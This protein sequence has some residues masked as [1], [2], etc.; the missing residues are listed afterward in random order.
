MLDIG[1]KVM[2]IGCQTLEGQR[3]IGRVVTLHQILT[4]G[5]IIDPNSV[6]DTDVEYSSGLTGGVVFHEELG[7]Y[8]A[9]EFKPEYALF[10]LKYLMPI[11]PLEDP[12]IDECTFTP[13]IQKEHA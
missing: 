5:A 8:A 1:M 3:Y 12:G 2:I 13:I 7:N 4:P 10:N 11:P 6:K 9:D